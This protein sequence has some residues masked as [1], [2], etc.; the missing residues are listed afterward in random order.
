MFFARGMVQ[1]SNVGVPGRG[2]SREAE[3]AMPSTKGPARLPRLVSLQQRAARRDACWGGG[4]ATRRM[5]AA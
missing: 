3:N 4:D 2:I 1:R 5:R